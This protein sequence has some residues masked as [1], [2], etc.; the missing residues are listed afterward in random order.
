MTNLTQT[1]IKEKLSKVMHP[2]I[3]NNLVDLGMIEDIIYKQK[4]ISLTLKLPFLE[5]PI[6][7]LLIGSIKKALS[8]LDSSI[9][10]EI[11]IEQMSQKQREKFAK[12]A[13][14]GWKF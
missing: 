3:N 12:M 4:H 11:N 14:E 7:D 13:K 10:V 6:K 5:V 1:D 2:E 9:R 8:D